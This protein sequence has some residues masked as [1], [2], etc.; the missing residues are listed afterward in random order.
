MNICLSWA[1]QLS[2]KVQ[3]V[4][5]VCRSSL[6]SLRLGK[7]EGRHFLL[8][9][10]APY[11]PKCVEQIARPVNRYGQKHMRPSPKQQKNGNR[12]A[13]Q[14]RM[15]HDRIR[16]ERDLIPP[17]RAHTHTHTHTHKWKAVIVDFIVMDELPSGYK[18]KMQSRHFHENVQTT[19]QRFIVQ[20][21]SFNTS[22]ISYL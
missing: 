16:D 21:S 7:E 19:K 12:R 18:G 8:A 14:R 20:T 2:E 10:F 6:R 15:S 3:K 13:G 9:S 17:A 5:A 4:F 11:N 1:T 22:S